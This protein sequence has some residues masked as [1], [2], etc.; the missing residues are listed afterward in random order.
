MLI[1]GQ[2]VHQ[3]ALGGVAFFI[4]A[5]QKRPAPGRGELFLDL[6]FS[7]L[8]LFKGVIHFDQ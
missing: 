1:I 8:A 7:G 6:H 4:G 3:P 2:D 5:H